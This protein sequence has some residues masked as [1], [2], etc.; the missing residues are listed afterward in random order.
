MK[1]VIRH[2]RRAA[3]LDSDGG[4]TD[5]QLLESFLARRE[6][7]A[8]E[9]LLRRHGPMVLGVCRRVLGNAHDADDAFQATFLVLLR[10]AASLRSRELVGNWL[11]GVAYRT[12]M[13]ARAMSA[14]RRT[15]ERQARGAGRSEPAGEVREELLARLD[16]E[17]NRL[18][19][20]YRVVV[21]LCDLEGKSREEAARQLQIPQ[22]TLSS[23]LAQ[24][25]KLLAKKLSRHGAVFPAG[26]LTAVLGPN[27]VSA[28]VPH[29]LLTS[30]TRAGML[31]VLGQGLTAGGVPA[32]VAA[33]TEGVMKA[34]LVS[35]LKAVTAFLL[36]AGTVAVGGELLVHPLAGGQLC[37]TEIRPAE[38][39]HGNAD[40][41]RKDA[42]GNMEERK[43]FEG[44]WQLASVEVDGRTLSR[45]EVKDTLIYPWMKAV[46]QNE[47]RKVP[48]GFSW[49]LL[50]VKGLLVVHDAEGNLKQ[51]TGHGVI[52][53]EGTMK[54]NPE[55]SPK[56]ID[57][58]WKLKGFPEPMAT[59]RGIY[60]FM[61]N[62]TYRLC[63]A[64]SGKD[65]PDSFS[66]RPGS[67]HVLWVFQR[68]KKNQEDDE[69]P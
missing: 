10:K 63:T 67:G 27:A 56:A 47:G 64:S 25:R 35:R 8:F 37:P 36:V 62:D 9:A 2:L 39:R 52:L 22:G 42:R 53:R 20:K 44:T 34:M 59:Q 54:I 16:A 40:A 41:P 58:T 21:V 48:E 66:T 30:T 60:E 46:A 12:A 7:A 28:G 55:R 17:L 11:Y 38:G 68:V 19:E 14:K 23:R 50:D 24:A 26:A 69:R 5:G 33:L 13:K 1:A 31:A 49:F 15:K 57:C 4:P 61:N 51:Q 29:P 18:P 3:L 6:E 45:R 65:L 43:R 32:R